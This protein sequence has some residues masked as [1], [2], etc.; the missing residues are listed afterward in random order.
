MLFENN[1]LMVSS[2]KLSGAGGGIPAALQIFYETSLLQSS[3][4]IEDNLGLNKFVNKVDYLLTGE[5]AYDYQSNYGKG[6]SVLMN[7]FQSNVERIFLICGKISADSFPKLHQKIFPIELKKYFTSDYDS[8]TNYKEGI[9]K[10][11]RDIVKQL[12]F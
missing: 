2:N 11:C 6:A 8:I 7:L 3:E 9:K 1:G 5:G 10:A 4:L 12:N